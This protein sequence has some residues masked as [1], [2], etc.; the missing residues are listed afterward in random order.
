MRILVHRLPPGKLSPSQVNWLVFIV[1]HR[2]KN[3]VPMLEA[4]LPI[5]TP[6][7]LGLVDNNLSAPPVA[8]ALELGDADAARWLVAHGA[9]PRIKGSYGGSLLHYAV[10]DHRRVFSSPQDKAARQK[11]VVE[12]A[13][14]FLGPA[15]DFMSRKSAGGFRYETPAVCAILEDNAQCLELFLEAGL[16]QVDANRSDLSLPA[17]IKYVYDPYFR[18]PLIEIAIKAEAMGC[19][20]VL[21]RHPATDL[22]PWEDMSLEQVLGDIASRLPPRVIYLFSMDQREFASDLQLRALAAAI[23]AEVTARSSSE[24]GAGSGSSRKRVRVRE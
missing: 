23:H 10:F 13:L 22:S 17:G 3:T 24:A 8:Q 19:A 6:E 14:E 15:A 18:E 5:I 21:A 12:A 1:L 20:M 11:A 16:K 9:D 7:C 4:M 2:R